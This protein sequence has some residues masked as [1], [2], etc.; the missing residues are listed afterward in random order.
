MLENKTALVTGA[1][2]GIGRE[3]A[4]SL[5]AAGAK[6]YGTATSE[7]GAQG[8]TTRL[9]EAG[10][11][12]E[13]RVLDIGS[14]DSIAALGEHLGKDGVD[15]LVNNAGINRDNLLLRMKPAEWDQVIATN[16]GGVFKLTRRLLRPMVKRRW[17]RIVNISSVVA[18]SGNPGQAN[19]C[20]AKAGIEG[21]TRSLA[22][23]VAS[24][25]I[26]A[27]SVAP[28]FIAT[29]MTEAL[30]EKQREVLASRIP[31]NRLGSG[32]DV[33]GAVLYL[34]SDA[35]AYVTGQTLHVNGGL[36]CG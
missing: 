29:D 35:G 13:G 5:A 11:G 16:L 17:G 19:Y 36:R 15:I 1:S 4:R 34:A 9:E 30:D 21:F 6:V 31:M 27:N 7:A 18:S 14:D 8:I 20:A 26:T 24:R 32:E 10:L 28:G 22:L 33:A 25:G 12:G 3:I 2:R 23:E